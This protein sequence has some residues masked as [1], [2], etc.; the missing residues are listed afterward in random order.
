MRQWVAAWQRTAPKAVASL[1]QDSDALLAF[2]TVPESDWR[3][4][5]TTNGIERMFRE[6]RRRTRPMTCFTNNASCE[7][8]IF[9]IFH[10]LNQ[11]QARR[12]FSPEF[13]QKS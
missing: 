1:T 7:R 6:I 10:A 12:P 4:V 5:R 2:Y 8:I 9:A 3:R 13:T 11:R